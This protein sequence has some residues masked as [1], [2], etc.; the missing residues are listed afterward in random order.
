MEQR[1]CLIP[2]CGEPV[3]ASGSWFTVNGEPLAVCETCERETL[4][5]DWIDAIERDLQE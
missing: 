4:Y 2:E 3:P 5:G 1:Y